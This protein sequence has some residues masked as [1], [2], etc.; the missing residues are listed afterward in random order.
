[1]N[2]GL[3]RLMTVLVSYEVVVAY[4]YQTSF[5]TA[6]LQRTLSRSCSCSQLRVKG[7]KM[8]QEL[9]NKNGA[10]LQSFEQLGAKASSNF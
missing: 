2:N 8:D 10:Q 1:M 7:Q 6:V 3:S 5:S 4:M 9:G